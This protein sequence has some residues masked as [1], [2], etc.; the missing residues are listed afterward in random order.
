MRDYWFFLSYSRRDGNNPYLRRFYETLASRV[1]RS[2]AIDAA[3]EIKDIGF[4]DVSDIDTG[5]VWDDTLQEAL[6]TSRV[7]VCMYSRSYFS[8]DYCGKEFTIFRDRLEAYSRTYNVRPPPLIMPVLWDRP[9]KLPKNLPQIVSEIQYPHD[10]FGQEYAEQGLDLLMRQQEYSDSYERFIMRFGDKLVQVGQLSP[11]LPRPQQVQT[12]ATVRSAFHPAIA[13]PRQDGSEPLAKTTTDVF[14]SYASQ[15]RERVIPIVRVLEERGYSVWWDRR[16]IPGKIFDQ[17]IED[18]IN[19]AKCV[20]VIWS[21]QSIISD[22]VKIEANEGR[23]R[24]IL[25]PVLIDNVKIPFA[26][27]RIQTASLIDWRGEESHLELKSVLDAI[28][29]L[30]SEQ[31][32]K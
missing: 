7:L 1:A 3:V 23:E 31:K 27:R 8:S 30:L 21:K 26:F 32:R 6:Q 4:F 12:L 11:P 16:I 15:D 2:A 10:E 25:I 17:M 20:I 29:L 13:P 22:W 14:I 18:A 19:S 24:R 5:D 28:N 9:D